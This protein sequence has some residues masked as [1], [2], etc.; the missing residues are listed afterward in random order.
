MSESDKRNLPSLKVVLVG[1]E[2]SEKTAFGY[3][4]KNDAPLDPNR[5][6]PNGYIPTFYENYKKKGKIGDQEVWLQIWDTAGQE[7][8][9]NIRTL[10]YSN[11]D[12]FLL[13]FSHEDVNSLERIRS[14]WAVEIAEHVKKPPA[15]VLVGIR[16][17][18]RENYQEHEA[19]GETKRGLLSRMK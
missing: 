19:M 8:L 2:G 18:V 1:D 14:K 10:S 15:L 5:P 13:L 6:Y 3:C 9:E 17:N 4:W 12:I 11:T 7:D 16:G